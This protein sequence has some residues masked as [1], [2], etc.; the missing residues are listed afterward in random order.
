MVFALQKRSLGIG[1]LHTGLQPQKD[2][3]EMEFCFTSHGPSYN[4]SS[5][6]KSIPLRMLR[7]NIHC[8]KR[9]KGPGARHATAAQ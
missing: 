3:L 9:N 1:V 2:V 7:A 8:L 6:G 5:S 4:S